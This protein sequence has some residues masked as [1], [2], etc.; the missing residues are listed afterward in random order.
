MKP[1]TFWAITDTRR[2]DFYTGTWH[3]RRDAI[4]KHGEDCRYEGESAKK[5]WRRRHKDGDRAVKVRLL[6]VKKSA[7]E[8][9]GDGRAMR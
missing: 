1:Q 6:R 9:A 2:G 8:R 3:T 5:A 4:A 7:L